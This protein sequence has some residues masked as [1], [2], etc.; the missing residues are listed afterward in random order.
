M[1]MNTSLISLRRVILL[2]GLLVAKP[3]LAATIIWSGAD[4]VSGNTNWSDGLNWTG[5]TPAGNDLR[6][7][8]PGADATVSNINNIVDGNLTILSLRY[9]NTNNYHTTWIKPG[10]TLT[11]S[12]NAAANLMFVGTLADNGAGEIVNATVTG[13]GGRLM[14]ISTNVASTMVVQ[15]GSGSSGA[16]LA[17]LDLSGLD[18]FN[19]TAGR[20]LPG[21]LPLSNTSPNNNASNHLTSLLILAKT[22]LISLNGTTTPTLNIGDA[23]SNGGSGDPNNVQLGQTNGLFIDTIAVGHSKSYGNLLFNPSLAGGNP[24]VYLRG[25]GATNRVAALAIGDN[26]VQTTSGSPCSGIVDLSLGTVDA[27]VNTCYVGRGQNGTGTGT[28]TGALTIGAG[29]FNVNTLYA[30]YVNI[31][32][33]VGKVTGTVNVTNGTLVVITNFILGYNPGAASAN[34]AATLNI[35]NG[36]VLANNITSTNGNVTSAINMTGGTL[37][38]SNTAGTPGFPIGTLNLGGATLQI[39]AGKTVA[40]VVVSSLTLADDASVINVSAVPVLFGYP[41][42]FPLISYASFSGGSMSLGTLPGTFKGYVSNDLTSVVWLVVTNGPSTAKADQWGGGVNN[43]WN[44]TTLNWTNAGV[45]VAYVEN[46]SVNFDDL[47]KTSTVNLTATRMPLGL[48]VTNN[49]L[50]YTFNGV[51][52]LTGPVGLNK[53]GSASLALAE[54]GGDNFS[55]GIVVGGGTV[56]LDDAN[57][58]ISGGAGITN[59]ATLQIGNNDTNGALPA[60][61]VDDQGTLAFSRSDNVLLATSFGGGGG[62]TQNGNGTLTLSSPV[63][64]TGNTIIGKG[65]LAL[66][67]AVSLSNSVSVLVSNGTFDVS[68]LVGQT[69]VLNSLTVTNAAFNVALSGLQAPISVVSSLNADGIIS[70]SNKINV[71]ALPI[72]ASYPVTFTVIQSAGINLAAGNFNFAVGS[73]PAGYAGSIS[74][75]P[76]NTA[77]LLTVTSGPIGIRPNVIWSG[78][79]G[80]NLNTNWSDRLNWFLP[81]VPTPVDNLIFNNT[82][83]VSASVLSTLGGGA[84]ALSAPEN[85]NN[86]VDANFTVSTVTFT[87]LTTYHNTEIVSGATLSITN[88]LTIGAINTGNPVQKGYVN[89]YGAGGTLSVVNSNA[90]VQVWNGDG[91]AASTTTGVS[92]SQAILDMSGLDNYNC[93]V[94]QIAVG[95]TAANAINYVSG[96]LY[97]AKTNNITT[98]F[99]TTTT[100]TS[101]NQANAGITV[102]DSIF[103]SGL[104]SFLYL[105]QANTINADTIAIGRQK[106]S[107]TL[108]FNPIYPNVAP[109]PTVTFQGYSSSAVGLFEVGGGAFNTGTTTLTADANLTGGIVNAKISTLSVGYASTATSGAGTTTGTLEFDA[110][111]ISAS[112]V[113]IGFHSV[114]SASKVGKGTITIGTNP[115]IVTN[116]TLSVSGNLNLAVNV[117]SPSTAGTVDINGGVL[118]ANAIVAGANG[119][120]STLTLENSGTLVVTNFAGSPAAPINTLNLNGGTLQ[121]NVNGSALV[122]N[123]VAI[124][125]NAGGA[126]TLNIGAIVNGL[127]LTTFPLISYTGSDPYSSITLGTLPAGFAGT[128]VDNAAN[129]RIDLSLTT[130]PTALAWV[131]AVGA[132]LNGNW[133]FSNFNWQ[134]LGSPAAYADPEFVTFNDSAS[135]SA[136]TL[137]ATV[138]PSEINVTNNTLNYVFGGSGRITGAA[139]ITKSGGGT[140]TLAGTG[141]DNFSGGITVGQNGGKLIL[142]NANS[143]VSGSTTIGSAGTLQIGN[144]DANGALP[145]GSVTDNGTLILQR[146]NSLAVSGVISGAGN[147]VQSGTG[148]AALSGVN[149]YGGGTLISSGTLQLVANNTVA[150]LTAAGTGPIT[151]NSVLAITNS[152]GIPAF[153]TVTNTI[154]GVGIINLPQTEEINFSGPGSMSGFTGTINIPAGT[155]LTAKGDITSTNINL[156]ATAVIN[157]ASGGTL[158]VANTGVAVPATLNL[159]GPG[160]SEGWGALRVDTAGN[161]SGP[162]HLLGNAT[163]GAQN[164]SGGT[165]SGVISD[166][167]SGYSVT[168]L[169][170]QTVILTGANTYSGGTTISNTTLQIGNGLVNGTLPG[171]ANIAVTNTTLA[172]VVATNTSQ[173]YSGVISGPGSLLENGFGG[174]LALNGMNTFTN[175]VTINAG[176]LWITNAAALGSGSKMITIVNGTAGHP[177]LHLNGVSGNLLLPATLAFTTSWIGGGGSAGVLINE[178]GNNEI[179]GNFNLFSGGGGSAFVVNGGTLKLAGTLVPTTTLRTVQLGGVGNGTVSGVIADNGT[180]LLTGVTVVGPGT[181]TLAGTNA[182]V[183]N[184]TVSGGTLLVNGVVGSG[185]LI[186]QASA[187]LGGS[188]NVGGVTTVQAGGTIQGGAATGANTLTVATLNLGNTNAITTYSQFN[189]AAGGKVAATALNVSGTNI[190][191][192]LD[193][194]LTIGTN[195]LFTYTGTI[196]GTNG[197]GGFQLGPLPSGVTAQLLNTGSA[198]KLA[199]TSVVT[200]NT[201]SPMLTNSITGNTLTLSWPADHL[202][203]RLQAQTNSLN[204]GLG[205]TW[206]TWPNSTNVTT[207]PIPLNAA[208]PTVFFRLIYP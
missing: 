204:T 160:N 171:N 72:L 89:I 132:T 108:Q 43:L 163:I 99:Q 51:G 202:G 167:G 82:A 52:S 34:P 143:A 85:F 90:S 144:S 176:A 154:G 9:G 69:A 186:V 187:T 5:G 164:T 45:A 111:N 197:F 190:V 130:T 179:D 71:L 106:T 56:I 24:S 203:W 63:S 11:V 103:N 20:L 18:N 101:G 124:T 113:N 10:V 102:G 104:P 183:T 94:A 107:A 169:G 199:V 66:T 140:L 80:L 165:I 134:N 1:L 147:L 198:V 119:A 117:N 201:N 191:Q 28:A 48:N 161:Y 2:T 123:I 158:W 115:S 184:T 182:Y 95:A 194:S 30:G 110:G 205:G 77:V 136:V 33:A 92:G 166:G 118:Q 116:A 37:V 65:T 61:V 128:L 139:S 93:T 207:V 109:Y 6:F 148:V 83:A 157:V 73:L 8:D 120:V 86:I 129:S 175:G 16:H 53:Q 79:D 188:G 38:V 36:V 181:W 76:D 12:N 149:A 162:V 49:V 25:R 189:V 112:T 19:L 174:T 55:G 40:N 138:S 41:S 133:N 4:L 146:A 60:G 35:S 15:Q 180:N 156:N 127:G 47:G 57:G 59:G 192:I 58:A 114:S 185:G 70:A 50:N 68:G 23:V 150:N 31:N 125:I 97:L 126:T 172:F 87:N 7:Y 98:T 168:K 3:V 17:V 105:G 96:I 200:V 81:G 46:D 44:T 67:N 84:G 21:G 39:P 27:Q 159:I 142:D 32:T 170:A 64:Y 13:A 122:T 177:E 131:G 193:P 29:V 74:E 91:A 178:A 78:A 153:V 14:V 26:S 137:V 152:G 141:G 75:S 155:T 208:N 88:T 196:G 151:N 54:T 121:L 22:N 62:L 206:F 145:G 135:N 173:T 100:D 42:Q 195:T